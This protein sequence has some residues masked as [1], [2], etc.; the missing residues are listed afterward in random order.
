MQGVW[1]S[2]TGCVGFVDLAG[3]HAGEIKD[4]DH[5]DLWFLERD[6][7]HAVLQFRGVPD[8]EHPWVHTPPALF[9]E[10]LKYLRDEGCRVIGL[11]D[12][13]RYVDPAVVPAN[14]M[15][16]FEERKAQK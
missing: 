16:V 6:L 12:L 4:A 8:N 13:A 1:E 2:L 14:P 15:A 5:D 11:R 9:E 10:Y 7:P 3:F